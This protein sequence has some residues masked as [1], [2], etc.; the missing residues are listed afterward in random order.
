MRGQFRGYRNEPSVAP[1][2]NVETF[3]AV[4]L[5]IDSW[6]WDGVPFFIRAGKC[7]PTT[8]TEV[9]VTL[10]RPPLS[11]VSPG[12]TNYF[13]FR[14]SPDVVI[15]VGARIKRP[16]EEIATEPTELKVVHKPEGDEMDAYERLLGD[17]MEGDRLLFAR[18]DGVE[19]AWA[20]VEPILRQNT[21]LNEYDCGTWGPRES[22]ALT[23][24]VGGW[25]SCEPSVAP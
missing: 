19:A 18:Q 3:A 22:E 14:L 9:T 20:I 23:A 7:L 4:R 2:S 8:T 17:A 6:R 13:R 25:H 16:G 21:P 10:Q 5:H 12:D 15:A 1:D 11:R 24:D